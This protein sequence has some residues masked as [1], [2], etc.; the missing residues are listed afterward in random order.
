MAIRFLTAL[1]LAFT[2]AFAPAQSVADKLGENPTFEEVQALYE[3]YFQK[4]VDDMSE[5]AGLEHP[6]WPTTPDVEF[7]PFFQR[8]AEDGVAEAMVWVLENHGEVEMPGEEMRALKI[9]CVNTL[10]ELPH[11][12]GYFLTIINTIFFDWNPENAIPWAMA[13]RILRQFDQ[14]LPQDDDENRALVLYTR[15][16][17]Q[18]A[19]MTAEA[20]RFAMMIL[21]RVADSY[22]HTD[23][24][25]MASGL[26]FDKRFLQVSMKAP[27]FTGNDVDGNP[28]SL[29]NFRGKVTYLVFWGFW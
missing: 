1:A 24:G 13:D 5:Q 20:D 14:R 18:E 10:M 26:I 23:A 29:S 8:V 15:Y 28:I 2:A 6:F 3:V 27:T 17:V 11:D 12:D 16:S 19:R 25:R 22:A 9:H 21:E 7:F 4:W